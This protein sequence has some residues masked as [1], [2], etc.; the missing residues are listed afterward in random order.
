MNE[1]DSEVMRGILN[2]RGLVAVDDEMNADI[3]IFNTCAVR[4]LAERKALGKLGHLIHRRSHRPIIGITGCM[5]NAKKESLFSKLPHVDFILGTNNIHQL[6]IVL[7]L[8]LNHERSIYVDAKFSEELPYEIASRK[9]SIKASV[10][11]IRGCNKHCTYC[12][13]PYTRGPEVSRDPQSIL[14]ECKMLIQ[15][16]YKEIMLLGQ[17]VNSYGKDRPDFATMFPDLLQRIDALPGIGRVRFMTSHPV[18]ISYELMQAIRDLPSVCEFVHFPVQ[19]GSNRILQKMNRKY[20]LEQYLEKVSQL[21]SLVPHVALGTDIIV[22]FPTETQEDFEMTCETLKMVRF[23]VAFMFAYSSRKQAPASRWVDDV[24]K[25]IKEERLQ[26]IL[27]LQESL[28][29]QYMQTQLGSTVEVL[30]EDISSK[31]G[32]MLKGKTRTWQQVV[33]PGN[34]SQ[35]GSCFNVKITSIANHTF[36]GEIVS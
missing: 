9:D 19:S 28:N 18:D 11:I 10:S 31:D 5:A 15:K 12:V 27:K 20:T 17:N 32:T 23:S 29:T 21:K 26:T 3:V 33:F 14:E 4:D 35:L 30:A 22:G 34:I 13:V 25:N 8:A 24:P 2:N 6:N 1:L 16:G 36:I 7:D